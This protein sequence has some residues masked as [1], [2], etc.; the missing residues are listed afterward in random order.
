MKDRL[1]H[2]LRAIENGTTEK[3]HDWRDTKK[4]KMKYK[5]YIKKWGNT[6]F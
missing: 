2:Y 1:K 4:G 5:D 6:K 3:Y